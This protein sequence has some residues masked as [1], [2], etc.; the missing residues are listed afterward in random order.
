V[1]RHGLQAVLAASPLLPEQA[2][3]PFKPGFGLSGQFDPTDSRLLRMSRLVASSLRL[4]VGRFFISSG[5]SALSLI[6]YPD[7]SSRVYFACFRK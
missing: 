6:R 5:H 3:G 1:I 7:L 2:G 4:T